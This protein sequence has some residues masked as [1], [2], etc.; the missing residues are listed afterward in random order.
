L[1]ELTMDEI[2]ERIEQ[3]VS[4]VQFDIEIDG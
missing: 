1:K 4:L 2:N 3:F